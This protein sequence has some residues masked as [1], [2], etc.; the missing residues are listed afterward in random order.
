VFAKRAWRRPPTTAEIESLGRLGD[1]VA[2]QGGTFDEGLA[3][4]MRAVL[5]SPHFLFKVERDPHS[6]SAGAH[7]LSDHEL[8]TRL[9]YFLWASTPD[10]ALLQLADE[11]RMHDPATLAAQVQRMVQDPRAQGFVDSFSG[12]WLATRALDDVNPDYV[13]FPAWNETLKEAMRQETHLVFKELMRSQRSFLDLFD[14]DFT[15]LNDPLAAHYGLTPP[16]SNEPV[17]VPLSPSGQ[18]SGIFT[19]ASILSVTSQPRRTS[20]VKRGKWALDQIL[21]IDIPPPPAGVEGMLDQPGTP[22]G[23]LRERLEQHRAN[24]ECAACHSYLDPIGLGLENYDAIGAW[25]SHDNGEP[26][27]PSGQ[28]PDGRTFAGPRQMAALVKADPNTPR[29]IAERVLIY[30][31][32]RGLTPADEAHLD[33]IEQQFAAGGHRFESL[34]TAIVRSEAFRMRRGEPGEGA[35]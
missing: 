4:G 26:V 21:C 3:L 13:Y 6:R 28:F 8:A 16:G 11:G 34:L 17:R 18:R 25:R 31:L 2:A 7:P 35:P 20:P 23:T 1:D 32:G 9:S 12:Q 14:A 30:A 19:H 5:S 29:C 10:D 27:D 33:E 24:P 22:V 15:Y